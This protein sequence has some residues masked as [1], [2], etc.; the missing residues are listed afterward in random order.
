MTPIPLIPD[1]DETLELRE[2]RR[3]Q[4][5][6]AATAS[7]LS[8]WNAIGLRSFTTGHVVSRRESSQRQREPYVG[9]IGSTARRLCGALAQ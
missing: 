7:W 4:A 3:P 8:V 6:S 5:R 2:G 1:D 9:S